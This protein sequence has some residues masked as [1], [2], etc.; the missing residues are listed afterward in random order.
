M[1]QQLLRRFFDFDRNPNWRGFESWTTSPLSRASII[2]FARRSEKPG[3][4]SR[5]APVIKVEIR[6]T[7]LTML[8]LN[9]RGYMS[10]IAETTALLRAMEEKPFL[11]CLNDTFLTKALENVELE[12]YQVLARRDRQGQW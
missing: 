3:S 8:F 2:G 11:V 5:D 10:H 1:Y 6:E 7:G 4:P 12:G 9:M